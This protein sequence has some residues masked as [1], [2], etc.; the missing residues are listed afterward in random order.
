MDSLGTGG[1]GSGGSAAPSAAEMSQAQNALNVMILQ[2]LNNQVRKTCFDK[3]FGS[4]FSDRMSKNEQICLAKCM[5]RMYEA[6]TIVMKAS[7]EMAQ[8]LNVPGGGADLG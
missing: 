7:A 1:L 4:R 6:H 3:C 8:N 2:L 5:D